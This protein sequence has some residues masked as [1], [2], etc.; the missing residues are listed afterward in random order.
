MDRPIIKTFVRD[1]IARNSKGVPTARVVLVGDYVEASTIPV[2]VLE[3]LGQVTRK[4]VK[5][6]VF[7]I[8]G[9]K[10]KMPADLPDLKITEVRGR[11]MVNSFYL[12][13]VQD[14]QD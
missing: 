9:V 6:E 14:E 12:T 10:Y 1:R 7:Y 3:L 2:A 11:L 8:D 13:K 5:S 4:A